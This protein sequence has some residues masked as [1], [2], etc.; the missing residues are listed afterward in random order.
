MGYVWLHLFERFYL[1]LAEDANVKS[2]PVSECMPSKASDNPGCFL[3]RISATLETS[4]YWSMIMS[5]LFNLPAFSQV[6][7]PGRQCL[8]IWLGHYPRGLCLRVRQ[9]GCQSL[10]ASSWW[11]WRWFGDVTKSVSLSFFITLHVSPCDKTK[12][13]VVPI[14]PL[15]DC[16]HSSIRNLANSFLNDAFFSKSAPLWRWV[17]SGPVTVSLIDGDCYLSRTRC[18]S[19]PLLEQTFVNRSLDIVP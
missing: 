15:C 19:S 6:E 9:W 7:W 10:Q 12:V 14:C 3:P 16:V 4:M 2:H 18:T 1:P 13:L 5:M 17:W 11:H 8:L